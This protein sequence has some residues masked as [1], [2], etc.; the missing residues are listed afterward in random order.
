[1]QNRAMKSLIPALV[2]IAGLR[3]AAAV[4]QVWIEGENATA[5]SFNRHSWYQ[6]Q[7]ELRRD[8]MSPGEPEVA[9]GNWLAHYVNAN[10]TNTAFASY[11][12]TVN[13][14]GTYAWW[15]RLNPIS[16]SYRFSIDGAV[17]QPLDVSDYREQVNIVGPIADPLIDI[18]WLAWVKVGDFAFAPTSAHTLRVEVVYDAGRDA[19]HG[20]IDAMALANDAWEPAGTLRP[21]QRIE[22][23]SP[24][25]WFPLRAGDDPFSPDSITDL[26]RFVHRPAGLH[27]PLVRVG[28][29]FEWRDRPGVA[30][31][32]I[33]TNFFGA[34]PTEAMQRRQALWL[35]KNG[36]NLLRI[37]PLQSWLGVLVRDPLGNRVLD[38]AALDQLDRW[39][40]ILKEH[41]IY[42][43]ISPF[44]P[45]AI[46]ADDGYPANLYAEL[47]DSG[48][49]K[50]TSG[51][52]AF[53]R[54][55]QDAEWEWVRIFLD[56]V[57]P[58]TTLA[59]KD[60]PV[61][62]I[63]EGHNEDSLFWHYP[64]N[65]LSN[66]AGAYPL[67]R[68]ELQRQWMEW[69]LAAYG[70]DVA[71][72]T[73][74]GAGLRAGD[75]VS[76]PA[77]DI[78]GAWQMSADGPVWGASPV[79]AERRRLGDFIRFLAETQRG[80][81]ERRR[82]A[83]RAIGFRGVFATTAWME[84]GAAAAG[85]NLWCDDAGDAIDRHA[86][87][88]G[89]GTQSW[90]V[91][92]GS[93]NNATHLAQPGRGIVGG[94]VYDSGG[95]PVSLYQVEDKPVIMSEWTSSPPNQWK[96]EMAPLHMLYGMGLQ[97]W[98]AS[99]HFASSGPRMGSGWPQNGWSPDFYVSET[100]HY[101]G[102][103]P[104]LATAIHG[105][106]VTE[107]E[108]VAAR[109]LFEDDLFRGVDPLTRSLP[110]VGYPAQ[111]D[112]RTP[113]EVLAIGRVTFKADPAASASAKTDWTASWDTTAQVIRSTTGELLW[114]YGNRVVSVM[115]PKT[116]GVIGWAAGRH[117]DLPGVGIDVTTPFVSLLLTALDDR[118][119]IDSTHILVTALARDRQ[120][121][122]LYDATSDNLLQV[123]GPPLLLEPV[124]ATLTFKGGA[125]GSARVVDIHGVP[126][127]TVVPISGGNAITIDGTYE[128]YYYEIRRPGCTP[129]LAR[130]KATLLAPLN[131]A[132]NVIF[133]SAATADA[134]TLD[135]AAPFAEIP[136]QCPFA[137]A[138]TDPE[139]VLI[140]GGEALIFYQMSGATT[141]P[142]RLVKDP[143]V[144][145]V[146]VNY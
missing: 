62:A 84:G 107:G 142:I 101:F 85:A 65:P 144:N 92:R 2:F 141:G 27:G 68:A 3:P 86:Y 30:V 57:N 83:L 77:M 138:S 20:G 16:A 75:S 73:A 102:Q 6:N 72:A 91:T 14:G 56:H 87:W 50:S 4:E 94:H 130:S 145:S 69:V 34:L 41:G 66:P 127:A 23:L 28:A 109:R 70:D 119:L 105:G 71:L 100:P 79:I 80:Y 110:G 40:A 11:D 140:P 39:V 54:A 89:G 136:Y 7:P 115:T 24:A 38:P 55:M 96:A 76:N 95:E 97:G 114:D 134:I 48:P 35:A 61:I 47:D 21:G 112:L 17:A 25:A 26:T 146:R 104:A 108:L 37:H 5:T 143:S 49:G 12:V 33:G 51:M 122:G 90:R 45:H 22:P 116:Q 67:H 120:W 103:Y 82:D 42:L 52:V 53:V 8:L 137:A 118:P 93:V 123:G 131:P 13:E 125:L 58:Y 98:D 59:Y 32:L 18:R 63:F 128:T 46:T 44:W 74:W 36:I 9:D 1:M 111:G 60:D 135:V 29:G 117:Y 133:L 15:I 124:Q 113:P 99:L 64:L 121:N 19:S 10:P 129:Y 88:G 43:A 106:H 78:Y 31:K 132:K 139:P 126:T 81:W